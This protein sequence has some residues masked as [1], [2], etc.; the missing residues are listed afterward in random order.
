MIS[1]QNKYLR[2]QKEYVSQKCFK[3]FTDFRCINLELSLSLCEILSI[4][5]A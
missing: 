2:K 3:A 4:I 5:A 1:Y